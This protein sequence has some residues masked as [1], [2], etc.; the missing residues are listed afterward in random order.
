MSEILDDINASIL[1]TEILERDNDNIS[2]E[3]LM[4][5]RDHIQ[6][7]E[8]TNAA[9]LAACKEGRDA[10]AAIMRA[11]HQSGYVEQVLDKMTHDYDGFGVRMD[12]AIK[13]A[14]SGQHSTGGE[15]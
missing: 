3:G 4:E 14:Q 8:T 9:L 7:L 12:A 1:A 6:R 5:W 2:L 11:I 13:L 15:T 10:A